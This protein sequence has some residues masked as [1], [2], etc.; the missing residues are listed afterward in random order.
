MKYIRLKATKG[1]S[2]A[3]HCQKAGQRAVAAGKPVHFIYEGLAIQV[4]H[5]R[6]GNLLYKK[7]NAKPKARRKPARK[8]RKPKPYDPFNL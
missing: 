5:D 6:I 3:Q 8:P 7:T 4:E 2:L 1:Q